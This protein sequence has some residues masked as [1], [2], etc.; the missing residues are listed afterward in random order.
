MT[1]DIRALIPSPRTTVAR[2]VA[3]G[4]DLIQVHTNVEN[5]R[6][7]IEQEQRG[8]NRAANGKEELR[9]KF[10]EWTTALERVYK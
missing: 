3:L 4:V 9:R 6:R 1:A 2:T 10:L 7:I 5:G 8:K